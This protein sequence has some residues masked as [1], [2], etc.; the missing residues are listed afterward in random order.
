MFYTYYLNVVDTDG[1]SWL[2]HATPLQSEWEDTGFIRRV[3]VALDKGESGIPAY[4]Y[5]KLV[6]AH[7]ELKP[8]LLA[9]GRAKL[10]CQRRPRLG[11]AELRQLNENRSGTQRAYLAALMTYNSVK[12][13]IMKIANG[14]GFPIEGQFRRGHGVFASIFRERSLGL[15]LVN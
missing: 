14:S 11:K 4:M 12:A 6:S 5:S 10:E 7:R 2:V 3:K 1:T 13:D 8:R 9:A 15:R